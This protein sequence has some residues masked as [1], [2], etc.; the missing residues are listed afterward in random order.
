MRLTTIID[1][2]SLLLARSH[3]YD[4]YTRYGRSSIGY[5]GSS[6]A[7]IS[8]MSIVPYEI[9]VMRATIGAIRPHPATTMELLARQI[10]ISF[11]MLVASIPR[12]TQTLVGLVAPSVVWR[13]R[14]DKFRY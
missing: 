12:T 1:Y 10:T 9:L 6:V 8:I 2:K 14:L 7:G 4:W 3:Y 11:S 5:T 13:T